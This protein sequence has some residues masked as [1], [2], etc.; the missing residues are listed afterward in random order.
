MARGGFSHPPLGC[1]ILTHMLS[2]SVNLIV[3]IKY[4]VSLPFNTNQESNLSYVNS[5][6]EFTHTERE[7]SNNYSICTSIWCRGKFF[8]FSLPSTEKIGTDPLPTNDKKGTLTDTQTNGKDL[9]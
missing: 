9:L 2:D 3:N 6:T 5:I 8:I 7:S 1:G 4:F